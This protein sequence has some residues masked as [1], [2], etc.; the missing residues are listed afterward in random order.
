MSREINRNHRTATLTKAKKSHKCS[1]CTQS[2]WPGE[3]Y[4]SITL[5]G[6]GVGGFKDPDRVH[7]ICLD[8]YWEEHE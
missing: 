7:N 3:T 1:T 6:A 4:W 8:K 5:N 2:I